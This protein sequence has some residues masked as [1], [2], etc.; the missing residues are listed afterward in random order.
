VTIYF[1]DGSALAKRHIPE[2][3]SLSQWL[4]TLSYNSHIHLLLLTHE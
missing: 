1:L 3:G 4:K 2:I